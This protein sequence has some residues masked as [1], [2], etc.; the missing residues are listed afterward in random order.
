VE[1]G[2]GHSRQP[3]HE[4]KEEKAAP[5]TADEPV[6]DATARIIEMHGWTGTPTAA[7]L[8]YEWIDENGDGVVGI[9][10]SDG[11]RDATMLGLL[12]WGRAHVVDSL[13]EQPELE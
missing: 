8:L 5:M 1:A 12:E 13:L 6:F 11:I 9:A 4:E 3:S 2:I 7:V 10:S